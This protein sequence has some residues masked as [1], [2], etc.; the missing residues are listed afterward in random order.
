MTSI[1]E[2]KKYKHLSKEERNIIEYMLKDSY[3]LTSIADAISRDKTTIAKE[4]KKHR[5][6]KYPDGVTKNWC[7]HRT[8]C[9]EF[10]CAKDKDCFDMFCPLLKKSPYVCNGCKKKAGCRFIKFYY[11]ARNA[12]NDYL[13]TLT[14]SRVGV[15]ISKDREKEIESIIYDLIIHKN[16]SVNEIYINYPDLLDFSKPTFYSYVNQGLF[17]LKNIDLRRKVT[18]KPRI[19]GNKRSRIE[20]KIRIN[21]TYKDF[22]NF[23]SLHPQFNIVEMDTVE[24]VKGGKVFLTL[25]FRKN[26]LMLIFLLENKTKEEVIKVF[27]Y[28]K[29]LLGKKIFKNLFRIILTDNGSEFFDP[30]SI[31]E[32]NNK[33]CI[34]LFY[35]DPCASWQK[36]GIEKNHEYIR[37]VLPKGSTFNYLNNED[38]NL[39]VSHINSTPRGVL[40]NSTPYDSFKKEFGEDILI[41]LNINYIKQ[42]EVNH[43][44]DLL[45]RHNERKK[46]LMKLINDLEHYYQLKHQTIDNNIKQKVIN[47]F[48]EDWYLYTNEDLFYKSVEIINKLI[49]K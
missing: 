20:T 36:G 33:K 44:S 47:N 9:K 17:H 31:E 35:C 14:N 28:L 29:S 30:D 26:N 37:Y 13:D 23:C 3:S 21:R 12:N 39:L 22:L 43:S 4:I 1:V 49:E 6:I 18:Y 7:I 48:L 27:D 10:N 46:S 40:K 16:Q 45:E 8:K 24:G 11:D 5:E 38:I 34:N 41:K 42:K 2:N 32:F 15:R 25:F 19:K